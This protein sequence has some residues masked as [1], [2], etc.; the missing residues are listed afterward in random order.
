MK[1]MQEMLKNKISFV[2]AHRLNT[3]KNSDLI[4]F[5]EDKHIVEAGTHEELMQKKGKYYQLYSSKKEKVE[6]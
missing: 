1:A 4:L 2:I 3:I 6:V 5:L